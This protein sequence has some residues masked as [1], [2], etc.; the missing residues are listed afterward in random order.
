M[1]LTLTQK[2]KRSKQK[3][4]LASRATSEVPSFAAAAADTK[5]AASAMTVAKVFMLFRYSEV[6]RIVQ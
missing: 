2:S 5:A 4:Q 6:Y 3:S 1:S